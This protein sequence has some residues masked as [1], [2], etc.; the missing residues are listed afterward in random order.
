MSLLDRGLDEGADIKWEWGLE[1]EKLSGLRW[2][3][4]LLHRNLAQREFDPRDPTPDNQLDKK[5]ETSFKG[6]NDKYHLFT[7]PGVLYI[8]K[9]SCSK[10]PVKDTNMPPSFTGS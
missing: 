9:Y 3:E 4:F 2:P 10:I 1:S 8:G 6:I 5:E 7:S